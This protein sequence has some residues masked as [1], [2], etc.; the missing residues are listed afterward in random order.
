MFRLEIAARLLAIQDLSRKIGELL[1]A[2]SGAKDRKPE[3]VEHHNLRKG[4]VRVD[5]FLKVR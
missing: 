4:E 5:H 1:T 3:G 2:L